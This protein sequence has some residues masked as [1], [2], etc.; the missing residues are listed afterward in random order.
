MDIKELRAVATELYRTQL[1]DLVPEPQH[2]SITVK[3][4]MVHLVD[5]LSIILFPGYLGA[6]QC[7][8]FDGIRMQER[9][10]NLLKHVSKTFHDTTCTR[11]QCLEQEL[12]SHY[13]ESISQAEAFIRKLPEIRRDLSYDIQAAYKGDPAA[14]NYGEII[15]AYPGFYSLMVYRL[16][17]QL[18]LQDVQLLPRILTEY[19]HSLTGIDIH[20]GAKLGRSFFID[21]GTGVV[22]GETCE[23]GDNVKIYQGVT[24]GALSI[25]KDT[26]GTALKSGKR[27]PTI[28]KDVTIYAGATILGGNTVIGEGSVIGGNVWLTESVPPYSKVVSR[29]TQEMRVQFI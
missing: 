3:K 9:L 6:W 23:I 29:P 26:E 12:C 7:D 8:S 16:A 10:V 5:E 28:E 24:L 17:H 2:P 21:H 11:D 15:L 19:A 14:K 1:E 13:R 18:Y 22:I 25:P 4:Q 27:H 20:P